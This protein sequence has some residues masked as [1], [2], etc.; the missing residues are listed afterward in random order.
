M[1]QEVRQRTPA[2]PLGAAHGVFV[3]AKGHS[4]RM[5]VLRELLG[6]AK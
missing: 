6:E 3:R 2:F 4:D 5:E 1:P